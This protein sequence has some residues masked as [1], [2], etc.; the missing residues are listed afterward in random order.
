LIIDCLIFISA[1]AAP[2]A[3]SIYTLSLHDAL[4]I[5]GFAQMGEWLEKHA[6]PEAWIVMEATGIY[7]EAL[8]TWLF[9][10][11]YHVSVVNP[12]QTA[13]YAKTQLSR[14]K[15]D[16]TDAKL[17]AGFGQHQLD[18]GRLRPWQPEPPAQKRLR[19]LVRRLADLR[20]MEQMERNRLESADANVQDSIHTV[21]RHI[22]EEIRRTL[23]AIE[24][25]IDSD[26]DL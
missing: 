4:P 13:A 16:R 10:Q 8:A 25:H 7:H 11:G 12:A 9:E 3:S 21:L 2:P 6:G 17:I 18:K 24:D 23:K 26:P 5:Y 22:E 20:E 15:T 1:L 19:A 14:G